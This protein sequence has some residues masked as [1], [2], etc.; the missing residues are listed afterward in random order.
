[1]TRKAR[2]IR[3]CEYGCLALVSIACL[4]RNAPCQNH[5]TATHNVAIEQMLSSG[6][7]YNEG[8][9]QPRNYAKAL[10][11]F[12]QASASGSMTG[13]AWLGSMQLL[14]HGTP[15]NEQQGLLLIRTAAESK[16]AIGLRLM[17]FVYEN[18]IGL[19]QDY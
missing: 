1:M 10:S 19:K 16:D 12:S 4:A 11:L 8:M 18:G 6:R 9:R 13:K 2:I 14:G 7:L 17:G 5:A 15:R 3:I